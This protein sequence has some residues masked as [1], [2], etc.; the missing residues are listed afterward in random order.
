MFSYKS[1][2][3]SPDN[4]G[5]TM[6]R[7][8]ALRSLLPAKRALKLTL[9]APAQAFVMVPSLEGLLGAVQKHQVFVGGVEGMSADAAVLIFAF[10][11]Q[12]AALI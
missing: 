11:S 5:C 4:S 6:C 7:Q 12:R 1:F 10:V 8:D 2:L 9:K 3:L